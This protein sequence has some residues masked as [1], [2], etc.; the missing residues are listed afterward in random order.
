MTHAFFKALLFMAA[1]SV[2]SAMAGEQSLD[3]MRGFRKAMPFTFACF[4][5]RRPRAGRRPALLRLLLQGR[6]PVRDRLARR[7]LVGLLRGRLHRRGPHRRLHVA[8]DLP[9]VLGRAVR[10]GARARARPP[11]PRA[12]RPTNPANGEIE[13]TDVGFPGPEHHIAEQAMPMKVAMGALAV[14]A[15]DRR[16]SCR[17]RRVDSAAREVPR[18]DVRRLDVAPRPTDG[19]RPLFGLVLGTRARRSRASSSPTGSGSCNP[20]RAHAS[21]SASPACTGSSSTSGTSTS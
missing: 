2:I 12:R 16:A 9:R 21:R 19:A 10:G 8:D 7:R 20:G 13:D 17:C 1:G 3:K 11:L 15:I 18:A 5:D 6:D 4:V 14:L